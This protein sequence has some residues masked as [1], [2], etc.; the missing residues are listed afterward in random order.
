[1][2]LHRAQSLG[3]A[4]DKS[5]IRVTG[6][7]G[8]GGVAASKRGLLRI[9]ECDPELAVVTPPPFSRESQ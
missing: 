4:F 9:E 8:T 2:A 5:N 3:D 1:M 6:G 7:R